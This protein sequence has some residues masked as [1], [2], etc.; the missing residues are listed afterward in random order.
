[1]SAFWTLELWLRHAPSQ[2]KHGGGQIS[3]CRIF[4][5]RP[6]W[7]RSK[8]SNGL[9]DKEQR[10]LV[11]NLGEPCAVW[12]WSRQ[13][14]NVYGVDRSSLG[15]VSWARWA[16]VWAAK[17]ELAIGSSGCLMAL[18]LGD[19]AYGMCWTAVCWLRWTLDW[20]VLRCKLRIPQHGD[21]QHIAGFP[22][23]LLCL[24]TNHFAS[25]HTLRLFI[26]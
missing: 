21:V 18:Q 11:E 25:N 14:A 22:L 16:P 10:A 1:M 3:R 12:G 5:R 13:V 15:C 24:S 26:V 8:Q 17:V 6:T 20:Y 7:S 2:A 19:S 23:V 9:S 4:R